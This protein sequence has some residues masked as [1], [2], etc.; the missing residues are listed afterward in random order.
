MSMICVDILEL[1]VML[2]RIDIYSTLLFKMQCG[3]H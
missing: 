2:A 1:M 3:I